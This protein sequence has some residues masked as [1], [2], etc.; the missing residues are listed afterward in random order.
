MKIAV[1]VV[2]WTFL[3]LSWIIP[4]FIKDKKTKSIVGMILSSLATGV[5]IGHLL[6]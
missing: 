2:G 1:I 4:L 6:S 5:F 3:L